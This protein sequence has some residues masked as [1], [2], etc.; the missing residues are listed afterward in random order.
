MNF[1]QFCSTFK[2]NIYALSAGKQLA[3]TNVINKKLFFDYQEFSEKEN[4]GNPD[5]LLDAINL[6]DN[7]YTNALE[8]ESTKQLM[9]DINQA[10]PDMD[11]FGG[12]GAYSALNSCAAVYESLDFLID[13]NPHHIYEVGLCLI[14]T[15]DSKIQEEHELTEEEIDNHPLMIETRNYLINLSQ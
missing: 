1:Q 10:C 15:V 4:F 13:R 3:F 11:D 6:L 8:P 7:S 9:L 12:N 2:T 5:L 14:N